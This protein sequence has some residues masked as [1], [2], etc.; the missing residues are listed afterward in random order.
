VSRGRNS[1]VR[2][3]VAFYK[4]LVGELTPGT[5]EGYYRRLEMIGFVERET[6]AESKINTRNP[7]G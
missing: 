4:P 6:D 3:P 1:F 5:E 7:E 2:K